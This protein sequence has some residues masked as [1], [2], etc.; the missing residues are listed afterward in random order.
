MYHAEQLTE[1]LDIHFP[2]VPSIPMSAL[3]S[4]ETLY[5]QKAVSKYL[6]LLCYVTM[7]LNEN[8]RLK[9]QSAQ[10]CAVFLDIKRAIKT[11]SKLQTN[12]H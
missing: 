7:K 9:P 4:T 10:A 8:T 1:A 2:F 3:R 5:D 6:A 11:P 12:L